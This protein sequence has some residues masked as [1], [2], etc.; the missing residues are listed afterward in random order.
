MISNKYVKTNGF[1]LTD[2]HTSIERQDKQ[3]K[4]YG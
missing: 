3:G 4:F 2:I 1:I